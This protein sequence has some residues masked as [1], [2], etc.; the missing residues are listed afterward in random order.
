MVAIAV[1]ATATTGANLTGQAAGTIS[2]TV[3]SVSVIGVGNGT[4]GNGLDISFANPLLPGAPQTVSTRF[5]NDGDGAEDIYLEFLTPTALHAFNTLGG[6]A[7]LVIAVNGHQLFASSDLDDGLPAHAHPYLGC[8][9]TA[10]PLPTVIPV[11]ANVA[12][13]AIN[14]W[15]FTFGYTYQ[16]SDTTISTFN[17]YPLTAAGTADPNAANSGLP[18]SI[19]A[20]PAGSDVPFINPTVV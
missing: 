13:G 3:G 14:T 17:P 7:T 8:N 1:T 6:T 2:G 18:Y 15:T 4:D 5:K 20:L 19:V 16:F 9:D 10:C 11:L 12:K